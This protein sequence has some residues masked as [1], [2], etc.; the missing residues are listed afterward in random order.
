MDDERH[1]EETTDETAEATP[2]VA[3]VD[4]SPDVEVARGD[5]GSAT[6]AT[7]ISGTEASDFRVRDEPTNDPEEADEP[8][9][10]PA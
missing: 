5:F 6:G 3:P 4:S 8:G 7:G 1:E 9:D 10:G 2:A